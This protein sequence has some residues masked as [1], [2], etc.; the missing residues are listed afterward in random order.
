M[1]RER[2]SKVRGSVKDL[3]GPRPGQRVAVSAADGVCRNLCTDSRPT[4]A[5]CSYGEK[6]EK[7]DTSSVME[8]DGG[9][10]NG[11]LEAF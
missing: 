6:S 7:S 11:D 5:Y 2:A 8:K 1:H 9:Q 3:G 10:R 4:T